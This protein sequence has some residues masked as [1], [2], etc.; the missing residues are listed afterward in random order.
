M[1]P[2]RVLALGQGLAGTVARRGKAL[3]IE[4]LAK[5]PRALAH[6]WLAREPLS[7]YLGIALKVDHRTVGVLQIYTHQP[8]LFTSDE[9][10]LLA[11]FAKKT[12]VAEKLEGLSH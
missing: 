7:S 11:Q 8:R 12:H 5:D 2:D 3:M 6:S 10:K 9:I 4:D 1:H